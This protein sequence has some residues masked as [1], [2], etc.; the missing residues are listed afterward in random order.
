MPS[1]VVLR[2]ELE[3]A[4]AFTDRALI[5]F[6]FSDEFHFELF[7]HCFFDDGVACAGYVYDEGGLVTRD[8]FFELVG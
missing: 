6:F 1:E 8:K 7:L 5:I 4:L 3:T 2:R